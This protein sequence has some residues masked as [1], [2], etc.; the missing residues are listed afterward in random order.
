[1]GKLLHRLIHS[2]PKLELAAF[3]QPLSR[4]CLV[5]EL[6]ITPDF[7]WD[8]KIH[9]NGEVF[10]IIVHDVD[11]EQILHHEVCYWKAVLKITN[12]YKLLEENVNSALYFVLRSLKTPNVDALYMCLC[13]RFKFFEMAMER[14]FFFLENLPG[15]VKKICSFHCSSCYMSIVYLFPSGSDS[16]NWLLV[17]AWSYRL[18]VCNVCRLYFIEDL[19]LFF[20]LFS[21][22]RCSSCQRF[23]AK[24]STL[25]LLPCQ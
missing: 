14:L 17:L 22:R 8:P 16:P 25:W 20:L 15:K 12:F 5:V 4:S 9:G 13:L 23:K 19:L 6:T 2:F 11:C 3:V 21:V 24:L 1:M 10:W 18:L 7:Q